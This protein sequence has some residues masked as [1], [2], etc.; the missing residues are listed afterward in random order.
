MQVLVLVLVLLVLCVAE[1]GCMQVLCV[2]FSSSGQHLAT[3]G[4]DSGIRIWRQK[5]LATEYECVAVLTG[6]SQSVSQP[7][8]GVWC[9]LCGVYCVVC[10][11][12]C[13]VCTVMLCTVHCGVCYAVLLCC[14]VVCCM[15]FLGPETLSEIVA[16]KT[17]LCCDC[18]AALNFVRCVS[19]G[20]PV[21]L[22]SGS[23]AAALRQP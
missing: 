9:V 1:C 13:V 21:L 8:C 23:V 15:L 7:L 19:P 17:C 16:Q 14:T 18:A 22:R 3:S 11:V 20:V 12:W 6:H 4:D 2:A 5:E 10:T